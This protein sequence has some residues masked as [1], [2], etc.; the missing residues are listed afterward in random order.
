MSDR[1]SS[2]RAALS[3]FGRWPGIL[4]LAYG[5]VG[6]PL[7]ALLMQ[8]IAYAGV[9]WACGHRNVA[10]VHIVPALFVVFAG[11]AIRISW[12][13][14]TSVGRIGRAENATITDR[15]RFVAV[16]GI[17][18]SAFSI[19]LILAMWLPLIIFDPCQR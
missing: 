2:E 6:A 15:T 5:F 16:S 19:V 4:G 7:S 18:L 9:Q 12:R 13:D 1:I 3:R 11:L 17:A 14:W 8:V 10:V